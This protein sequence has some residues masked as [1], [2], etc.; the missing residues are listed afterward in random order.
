MR[1]AETLVTRW[2]ELGWGRRPA[3]H[4]PDTE[5]SW[6]KLKTRECVSTLAF[7]SVGSSDRQTNKQATA[8]LWDIMQ[9]P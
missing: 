5:G 3:P 1:L 8:F 9:Q 2:K 6:E 7:P 4:S